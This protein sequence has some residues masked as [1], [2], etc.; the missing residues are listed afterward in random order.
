MLLLSRI[1]ASIYLAA[2]LL[3]LALAVWQSRRRKAR[4]AIL[5]TQPLFGLLLTLISSMVLALSIVLVYAK[6]TD[7][8]ASIGQL[9][10]TCYLFIGVISLLKGFNWLLRAGADRTFLLT[11]RWHNPG[12]G[13][14]I[15]STAASFTRA[16]ILMGVGLPLVMAIGM[17]YRP[18]VVGTDNPLRYGFRYEHVTFD[19]T[20]G[21][22]LDAWWVPAVWPGKIGSNPPADW[23]KRTVIL[24]HGLG[25]NKAN[26]LIV[27]RDL[28]T[29]GYNVLAFDFRA[30]GSSGGQIST[31]GA[32]EKND[33]LGAVH[34]ARDMHR[35]QCRQL[36]G[37]GVSMGGAALIGAAADPSEEGRAIDA[38]AVYDTYDDLN[39]L[40]QDLTSTF[41]SR[42]CLGSRPTWPCRW[43]QSM[44][45]P[46]WRSSGPPTSWIESHRGRSWL[47]T[48]AATR[49]ST[50]TTACD[51][52]TPP[53]NRK[54]AAGSA[55]ARSSRRTERR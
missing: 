53:R 21:I 40:T 51:C 39:S 14:R 45:A 10:L 52:L 12:P 16:L 17:V 29:H 50:S 27:A 44:P 48:P 15:R 38:V 36:F 28:P 43:R 9:A 37:L 31:F 7:A 30:H 49:S 4:P 32:L 20:D 18:K 11:G 41:S 5:S 6:A 46:T 22:P 1:L 23:G 35:R 42:R 47:S 8:K 19:S 34:W 26:E 2:P 13:Y 3:A 24:C 25:S 55:S 33:V 54:S